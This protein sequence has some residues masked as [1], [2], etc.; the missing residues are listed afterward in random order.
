MALFRNVN[1]SFW[2]D[3]K[4]TDDFTPEDKYF[5]LYCLTNTYTNII[6]CYEISVRQISRDM[7]YSEDSIKN[8]LKRFSEIHKIIDYDFKTKELFIRNWG[9]YN[10]N[11]SPKLDAPLK[12]AIDKVKSDKFRNELADMYNSRDT[13][14]IPYVYPTDTVSIPYVYPTDTTITNTITNSNT[15]AIKEIIDYL[16]NK[17]KTRYR[18]TNKETIKHINGRMNDGYTIDDFKTVIDKKSSEWIGTDMEQY[19]RPSTLFSPTNFENYLNAKINK[20]KP[21]TQNTNFV[22]SNGIETS[23]PFVADLEKVRNGEEPF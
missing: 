12:N 21:K 20:R 9:K 11:D 7:G 8:L 4:V 13:V 10:W 18:T 3:T 15:I 2:T 6:G 5:M 19:L 14:S 16:N 23:N 22:L 17:A 1:M